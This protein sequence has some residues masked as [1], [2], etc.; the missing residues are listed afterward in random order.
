MDYIAYMVCA[1]CN[2]DC[3]ACVCMVCNIWFVLMAA[4]E[5]SLR[6]PSHDYHRAWAELGRLASL[7]HQ[8]NASVTH[9]VRSQPSTVGLH[10]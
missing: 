10:T 1:V 2:M 5:R 9:H 4:L 7:S 3:M 6:L 8:A